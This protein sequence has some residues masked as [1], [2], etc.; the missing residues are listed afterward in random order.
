MK[1]E[2]SVKTGARLNMVVLAS[3]KI[4]LFNETATGNIQE[5]CCHL[6]ADG[7][8]LIVEAIEARVSQQLKG[9]TEY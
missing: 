3:R 5:R 6:Q 4:L 9:I 7:S 2:K 1:T 8:P